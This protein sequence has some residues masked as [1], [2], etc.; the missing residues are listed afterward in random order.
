MWEKIYDQ[1]PNK[2]WSYNCGEQW[3]RMVKV[4]SK[5]HFQKLYDQNSDDLIFIWKQ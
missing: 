5:K 2:I 3:E 1:N 4:Q